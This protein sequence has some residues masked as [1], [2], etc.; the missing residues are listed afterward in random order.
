MIRWARVAALAGGAAVLYLSGRWVSHDLIRNLGLFSQPRIMTATLVYVVLMALPFMPAAEIGLALLMLFG[1]KAAPLVYA[2]TVAALALAYGLGRLV[3]AA[4]LE[5]LVG[6]E[7]L[8][9][10]E[11][12]TPAR[13]A[14]AALRHRFVLLVLLFNLPGNIAIGGGGGIALVAGMTRMFPFPAFLAAVALA[15]APVPLAVFLAG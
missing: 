13:L 7:R 11:R 1:A 8:A 3:P 9:L 2:S 12:E 10:L 5:K 6:R 4:G 15:V 14:R